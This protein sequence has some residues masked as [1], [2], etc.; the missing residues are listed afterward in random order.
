MKS[1]FWGIWDDPDLPRYRARQGTPGIWLLLKFTSPRVTF[2]ESIN[3][4]AWGLGLDDGS[5]RG[6][7]H[8]QTS[9]ESQ[10]SDFGILENH[11]W[12]LGGVV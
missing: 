4:S 3:L 5:H 6:G 12:T 7:L 8:T 2:Q 1:G 9:K 11:T 10:P